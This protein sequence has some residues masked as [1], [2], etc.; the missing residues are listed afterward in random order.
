MTLLAI[1]VQLIFI[2]F[3]EPAARRA[4]L[5]W[6]RL[7]LWIIGVRV[8]T[9]GKIP[10]HAPVLIVSNHVSWSDVLV[11]GSVMELCF[12]AKSEV[13]SWPVINVLAWMQRTVFIDRNRR[14]DSGR[15][16]VTIAKRMLR[17]DAM[18]LFAEGTTGDGHRVLPFKS[19]LFGAVQ[20]ALSS[21][22]AQ[23]TVQP[24]AIAYTRLHGMPLGRLHQ[25]R[26][27]WPGNVGLVRHLRD[28]LRDG[29]YDVD[30]VFCPSPK[31]DPDTTRKTIAHDSFALVRR[32]YVK[33]VRMGTSFA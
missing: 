18:V 21:E 9:Y 22:I 24:V 23:V 5:V 29:A 11:L 1:P 7:A 6:H 33:S 26:A 15:Q 10:R 8:F 13:K 16:S 3:A 30:V 14:A 19:A 32:A 25:A 4:A 2:R 20:T 28:F 17:G 27:S 12:V 31:I